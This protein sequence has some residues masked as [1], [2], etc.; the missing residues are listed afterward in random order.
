MMAETEVGKRQRIFIFVVIIFANN[1]ILVF[2]KLI[3]ITLKECIF[4]LIIQRPINNEMNLQQSVLCFVTGVLSTSWHLE[5]MGY[6]PGEH[7]N[8]QG[9]IAN[10]M[11]VNVK[12]VKATLKQVKVVCIR[13]FCTPLKMLF[14]YSQSFCHYILPDQTGA[15]A[16]NSFI[17]RAMNCVFSKHSARI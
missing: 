15:H 12:Q 4:V 11:K 10:H 8:V 16:L 17:L 1:Y 14:S 2:L 6:L 9:D 13:S 3:F 7:I 5:K